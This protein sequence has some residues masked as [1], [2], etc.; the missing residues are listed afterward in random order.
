MRLSQIV[1]AEVD[2]KTGEIHRWIDRDKLLQKYAGDKSVF[3]SFSDVNKLGLNPSSGYDTPIGIYAYPVDYVLNS[4]MDD[5]SGFNVPFAANRDFIIVF[6]VKDLS[7]CWVVNY[8]T[9]S[10]SSLD[11]LHNTTELVNDW[12]KTI[13]RE[14]ERRLIDYRTEGT[15]WCRDFVNHDLKWIRPEIELS[16]F[17]EAGKLAEA[18]G[19]SDSQLNAIKFLTIARD[20][21]YHNWSVK[22]PDDLLWRLCRTIGKFVSNNPAVGWSKVLLKLGYNGVIDNGNGIIHPSEPTQAVFFRLA[23]LTHL[24]TIR[25]SFHPKNLPRTSQSDRVDRSL[26]AKR[27]RSGNIPNRIHRLL[28]Y[29]PPTFGSRPSTEF[30]DLIERCGKFVSKLDDSFRKS[31]ARF[32]APHSFRA[33]TAVQVRILSDEL[34]EY[35]RFLSIFKHN[36]PEK[37][38]EIRPQ[39]LENFKNYK[40]TFES[41]NA[42]RHEEMMPIVTAFNKLMRSV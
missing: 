36:S 34:N 29:Y 19:L 11:G 26:E 32:L 39:L 9:S 12:R 42:G 15:K 17:P 23:D 33:H 41:Y 1:E 3:V 13:F 16:G 40:E 38:S 6:K 21:L 20:V 24:E 30:I 27:V 35:R 8:A 5:R 37:Y 31:S 22:S 14:T 4:S 2:P 18:V 10:L 25:N 7:K 28:G